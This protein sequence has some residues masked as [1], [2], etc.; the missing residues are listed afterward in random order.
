M[1]VY[2]IR[3]VYQYLHRK[4]RL[5]RFSP[6]LD[7]G[8]RLPYFYLKIAETYTGQNFPDH[9]AGGIKVN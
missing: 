7:I 5:K 2:K 1:P 9:I 4:N 8:V 3:E 6:V